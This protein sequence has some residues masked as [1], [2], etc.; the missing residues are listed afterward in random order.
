MNEEEE[1]KMARRNAACDNDCFNCTRPASR[2]S[3]G[4]GRLSPM[5]GMRYNRM[6]DGK[7]G[8]SAPDL[9]WGRGHKC[10]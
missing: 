5:K 8:E 9:A 6:T 7:K 10:R 3:G 2:C 4:N 1:E